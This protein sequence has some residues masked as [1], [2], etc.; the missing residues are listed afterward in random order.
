M[1]ANMKEEKI[2]NVAC[3]TSTGSASQ[4]T[5][6]STVVHEASIDADMEEC[7]Q[8]FSSAA[9]AESKSIRLGASVLKRGCDLYSEL[10]SARLEL[11]SAV[12]ID[13]RLKMALG[14]T[15]K[16]HVVIEKEL[17]DACPQGDAVMW[18]LPP[19]GER[20]VSILPILGQ[21]SSALLFEKELALKTNI[22]FL[23]NLL[24]CSPQPR[25]LWLHPKFVPMIIPRNLH[26]AKL[27]LMLSLLLNIPSLPLC[28]CPVK[29]IGPNNDP[30]LVYR[31]HKLL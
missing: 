18:T 3:N 24:I 6:H 8:L 22:V 9:A 2:P 7:A 16:V 1:S 30:K 5:P 15:G 20:R 12:R 29:P 23:I 17:T 14:A 19:S 31:K 11:T 27:G 26:G 13:E 28:T 10:Q 21:R 4:Q 25:K